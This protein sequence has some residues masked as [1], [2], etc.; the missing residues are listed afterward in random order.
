[1]P[2]IRNVSPYGALDVPLLRRT[3]DGGEVVDVTAEQAAL[4]LP[5]AANY[6]P[7]DKAARD[8]LAALQK[9]VEDPV[10]APA[11]VVD[12]SAPA[13]GEDVTA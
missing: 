7:A 13:T 3:V 1:M 9:A 5:Q 12:V 8:I 11:P 2:K 6:E 4:L 10:D